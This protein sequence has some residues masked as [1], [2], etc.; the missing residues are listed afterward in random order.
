MNDEKSITSNFIS[1]I[2]NKIGNNIF[3]IE[4]DLDPLIKRI[5]CKKFNEVMEIIENIRSSL[6][7]AKKTIEQLK[8]LLQ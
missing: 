1:T 6:E 5:E 7:K 2:I 4:T 3:A 8:H